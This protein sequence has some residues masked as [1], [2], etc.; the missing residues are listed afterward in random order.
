MELVA[1]GD[2]VGAGVADAAARG[3]GEAALAGECA[4]T[5][6]CATE[7]D[8]AV[9]DEDWGDG[10]AFTVDVGVG[11]AAAANNGRGA[12]AA[13]EVLTESTTASYT[14]VEADAEPGAESGS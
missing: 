10:A 4:I 1:T 3:I 2:V 8:G 7:G 14:S 9:M 13:A 6:E 12:G 5:G 11:L